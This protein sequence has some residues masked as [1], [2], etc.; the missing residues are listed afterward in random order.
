MPETGDGRGRTAPD[1][2]E[3]V[4]VYKRTHE[5]ALCFEDECVGMRVAGAPEG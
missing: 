2:G 3:I 1:P 4:L 5:S